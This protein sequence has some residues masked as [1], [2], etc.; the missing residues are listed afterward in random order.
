M[1]GLKPLANTN[2]EEDIAA[3]IRSLEDKWSGKQSV[4]KKPRDLMRA[5]GKIGKYLEQ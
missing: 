5:I 1:T 4:E 3:K 2:A